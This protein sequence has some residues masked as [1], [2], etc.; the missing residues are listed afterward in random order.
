MTIDDAAQQLANETGAPIELVREVLQE[1]NGDLA[2][3]RQLLTDGAAV[4]HDRF[5]M[6]ATARYISRKDTTR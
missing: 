4:G 1:L 6:L 3:V 2:A 5:T